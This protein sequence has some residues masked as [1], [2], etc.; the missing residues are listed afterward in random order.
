MKWENIFEAIWAAPSIIL[1]QITRGWWEFWVETEDLAKNGE[2]EDD[3]E[4][5]TESQKSPEHNLH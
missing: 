1:E 3:Q 4:D 5:T 2:Y